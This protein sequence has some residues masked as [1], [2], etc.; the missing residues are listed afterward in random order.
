LNFIKQEF[1]KRM[2]DQNKNRLHVQYI[3]AR[4]KKDVKYCWDE[5]K[6]VLLE[7]NKKDVREAAKKTKKT[8]KS[9]K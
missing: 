8:E 7:E 5:L 1:E 6:T 4:F 2:D 9:K 3:A